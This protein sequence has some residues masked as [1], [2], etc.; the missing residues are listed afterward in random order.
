VI[1]KNK[2]ARDKARLAKRTAA[3]SAS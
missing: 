1:H 2:A 3:T